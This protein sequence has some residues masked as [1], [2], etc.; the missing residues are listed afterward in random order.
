MQYFCCLIIQNVW[1]DCNW[2][3]Q[4]RYW[5]TIEIQKKTHEKIER[6]NHC[7]RAARDPSTGDV[8][9]SC[10]C[11]GQVIVCVFKCKLASDDGD[12]WNRKAKAKKKCNWN[13]KWACKRKKNM[14][15]RTLM[16]KKKI[17]RVFFVV[18]VL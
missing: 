17:Y 9:F 18:V 7:V 5:I 2:S 16:M 10:E 1:R 6:E 8:F 12:Q 3:K 11:F 13:N 14:K 4:I 15:H